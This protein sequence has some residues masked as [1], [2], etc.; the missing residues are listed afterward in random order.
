MVNNMLGLP[1]RAARLQ[2][3]VLI[4]LTAPVTWLSVKESTWLLGQ[5]AAIVV[6]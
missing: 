4:V 5:N 1:D 6:W 3:L 2:G